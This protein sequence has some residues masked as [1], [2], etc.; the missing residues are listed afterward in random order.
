MGAA[1][2]VQG[3]ETGYRTPMKPCHWAR[4]ILPGAVLLMTACSLPAPYVF[5][6]D[7]FNREAPG[8]GKKPADIEDVSICYSS[9]GTTPDVVRR[10]AET[11][12]GRF[13]KVAV[14]DHQDYQSCALMTPR[15]A[16]FSCVKR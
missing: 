7:E 16:V 4:S 9:W 15:R 8:F 3:L 12:C 10:M 13:D 2:I 11:E 6:K 1:A 5:L 14:L